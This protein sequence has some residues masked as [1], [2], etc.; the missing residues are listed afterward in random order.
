MNHSSAPQG[1]AHESGTARHKALRLGRLC[2][3]PALFGVTL[4]IL[5]FLLFSLSR[6]KD[7]VRALYDP[8]Q[9]FDPGGQA[10]SPLGGR[11]S[12]I[13]TSLNE[14]LDHASDRQQPEERRLLAQLDRLWRSLK[15]YLNPRQ[16][17]TA[18]TPRSPA[19]GRGVP[20]TARTADLAQARAAAVSEEHESTAVL[21]NL[22]RLAKDHDVIQ[23]ASQ[24]EHAGEGPGAAV[25]GGEAGERGSL[26]A[27][28]EEPRRLQDSG[29]FE[30]FSPM[31]GVR[32]KGLVW[33]VHRNLSLEG[34]LD[35][36]PEGGTDR[37]LYDFGLRSVHAMGFLRFDQ[38]PTSGPGWDKIDSGY[39]RSYGIGL[40]YQV[41]TTM[42]MLFDYFHEVPNDHFIEYK[43]AWES[44]LMADY[45]KKRPEDISSTHSF[46][47]GLRYLHRDQGV[48]LPFHTGFFYSTNMAPEPL[49]SEVSIGFGVGGGVHK[50]DMQLGLS[51]RL[52]IWQNPDA[53]L[54]RLSYTQEE[55][56]NTRISNQLLFYLT[57]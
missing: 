14:E 48:L 21:E 23:K 22:L 50:K 25:P 30:R 54:V 8:D 55:E 35:T 45:A 56:L 15:S 20:Q 1:I 57:F 41:S 24:E 49:P 32:T 5:F 3:F 47:F 46:F 9:L 10:A 52:R 12:E 42:Q 11:K 27:L 40:N 37:D 31:G 19:G 51:Y 4:A 36:T 33:R 2:L 26:M 13:L 29:L 53:E 6:N 16:E 17:E 18:G 44:S 28:V 43:G 39:P 38:G 34:T 7:A